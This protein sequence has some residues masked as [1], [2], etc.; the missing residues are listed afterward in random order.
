[1]SHLTYIRRLY[2]YN[3]W[4]NRRALESMRQGVHS[5]ELTLN[6]MAH[7]LA[8]EVTWYSRLNDEPAWLEVWPALSME[9][10]EAQID[11]MKDKWTAFLNTLDEEDLTGVIEYQNSRGATFSSRRDDVLQHVMMHGAYHRGQIAASVRAAGG[12]PLGTDYIFC[13]REGA[14]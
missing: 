1:M 8:A 5:D 6:R 11:T 7:I 2:A 14:I 9:Q 13:V 4:A 3:D 10:I 12:S